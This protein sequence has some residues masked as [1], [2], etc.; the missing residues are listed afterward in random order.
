MR[1]GKPRVLE[2]SRGESMVCRSGGRGTTIFTDT[3]DGT[4]I[5]LFELYVA[6]TAHSSGKGTVRGGDHAQLK[7]FQRVTVH[8]GDRAQ[9]I[10][11]GATWE[12]TERSPMAVAS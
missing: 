11:W 8:G 10:G 1:G 5:T 4:V 2:E 6:V 7:I 12:C 3:V 9:F